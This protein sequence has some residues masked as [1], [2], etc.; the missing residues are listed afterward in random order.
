MYRVTFTPDKTQ[1]HTHTQTHTLGETPLD[2]GSD[3]CRD[4]LPANTQHSQET[5]I[6]DAYGNITQNP[7][8]RAAVDPYRRQRGY[9]DRA[10]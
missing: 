1:T 4:L 3:G 9:W 7:S 5:S 8:K 2:D 6:H 10:V